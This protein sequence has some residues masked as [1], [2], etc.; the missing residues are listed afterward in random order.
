MSFIYHGVPETM[1]GD[2]L[3]PLNLMIDEMSDIQ[4]KN[5]EKYRGREEVLERRVPLLECAWNDVV[6]FLPL[7]PSNVFDLQEEVGLIPV[8]PSYKFYE[9]DVKII[10]PNNAVVFFKTALGEENTEVKWL[11]DVDLDTL[12]VIPEATRKYYETLIGTG[13]LPFNYQFIPHILYK[14]TVNISNSSIITLG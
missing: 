2:K 10:D 11:K 5:L 3:V 1:F 9:I 8:V 13:E 14:G 6:Q 12:K 4:S 7:H